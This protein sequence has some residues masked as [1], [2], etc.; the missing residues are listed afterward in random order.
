MEKLMA[1]IK[2]DVKPSRTPL[3]NIHN[4]QVCTGCLISYW[5]I[6]KL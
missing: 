5:N 2:F 6:S 4:I 1:K 3:T